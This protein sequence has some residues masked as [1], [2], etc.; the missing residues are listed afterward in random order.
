[1]MPSEIRYH[2][3]VGIL[4]AVDIIRVLFAELHIVYAVCGIV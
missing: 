2:K 4:A 3:H 1:M